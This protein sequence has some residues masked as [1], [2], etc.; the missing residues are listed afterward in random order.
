M[1]ERYSKLFALPENLYA[2]GAPVVIAAG[3][4]LKDNQ[5]GKVIAQLKMR[6]IGA[7]IIKAVKVCIHPL[8]TVGNTLGAEVEYQ[9]LDLAA[10]RNEEFGAK[11]P[12][13]LADAATRSYSVSVVEV[14]FTD[15][16]VWKA[17]DEPW[18][19]LSAPST[20]DVTLKDS[21][22]LKQYRIKYGTNC[23]YNP[24]VQKDLWYCVC[25]ELNH[26]KET[27]C[28]HCRKSLATLQAI[29]IA[30]LKAERDIRIAAEQQKAAEDKAA[31]DAKAKKAKKLAIIAAPIVILIIIA[32]VI[33]SNAVKAKQEEAARLEAYN[34]AVAMVEAGEYDDAIAA[35][36]ALGEYKDSA[37]QIKKAETAK[38]N[39]E[40]E[41]KNAAAYS[42]AKE[43]MEKGDYKQAVSEFE[44]LGAYSDSEEQILEAKYLEAVSCYE[45]RKSI[46][47]S[48]DV[49]T[50]DSSPEQIYKYEIASFTEIAEYKDAQQKADELNAWVAMLNSVYE[51]SNKYDGIRYKGSG[52]GDGFYYTNDHLLE[53][54]T[55]IKTYKD[56]YEFFPT[57]SYLD[58]ICSLEPYCGEWTIVSGNMPTWLLAQ[59]GSAKKL[60]SFA[61]VFN[62][63]PYRWSY[64]YEEKETCCAD[65]GFVVGGSYFY[66]SSIDYEQTANP[67]WEYDYDGFGGERVYAECMLLDTTTLN[68]E[69]EHTNVSAFDV[70]SGTVVF[71]KK[72]L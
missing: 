61:P 12:I 25:G 53:A 70:Q 67:V 58:F 51:I 29:D 10:K 45:F 63:S 20:L 50:G 60:E 37:N 35:L 46:D 4:L 39:A 59:K 57:T 26:K 19:A 31:A 11:S 16:T 69:I 6:N 18:E 27:V 3:A 28:H 66:C 7:N 49:F 5:T 21:E 8:D 42:Y 2:S 65:L 13:P 62:I 24:T 68:I 32:A 44:K 71:E 17:M 14:V 23:K 72:T 30:T 36:E 1:S 34:A 55:L 40:L 52:G 38:K 41:A 54:I 15:N 22:L 64:S 47:V 33:I 56:S 48:K 43:L 9:Y